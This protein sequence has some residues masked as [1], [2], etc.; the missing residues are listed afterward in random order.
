MPGKLV[1]LYLQYPD[2]FLDRGVFVIEENIYLAPLGQIPLAKRIA[3]F[4]KGLQF[5]KEL[6]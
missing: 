3:G 4:A 2:G 5:L 1:S 6:K